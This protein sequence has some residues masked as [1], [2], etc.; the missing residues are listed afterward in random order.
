M[1]TEAELKAIGL[2]MAADLGEAYSNV[3]AAELAVERAITQLSKEE[4]AEL[5]PQMP[6]TGVIDRLRLNAMRS[7]LPLVA[8]RMAISSAIECENDRP[9]PR[10]IVL[11][12]PHARL[13]MLKGVAPVLPP[14][15]HDHAQGCEP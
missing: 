9:R 5:D 11:A 10:L 12:D 7:A 8:A 1:R 3:K 6:L 2:A 14:S 4:V 15:D 13:D